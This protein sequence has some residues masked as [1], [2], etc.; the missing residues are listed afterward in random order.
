VAVEQRRGEILPSNVD[1]IASPE[2][3]AK[4]RPGVLVPLLVI[5]VAMLV[6]AAIVLGLTSTRP[7][8]QVAASRTPAPTSAPIRATA[9]SVGAP[10]AQ[11][12]RKP[13]PVAVPMPAVN[14][15]SCDAL[16]STIV[17]MHVHLAIFFDGEE[18]LVPFGVGIGEPW[19]VSASA[20]GPFVEDGSCFYWIHTH[21]E[22]G[23]VHIESPIRRTFTLGDFF[24][25]WE[26][27]LSANQVGPAQGSVI[28]YV[29][30]DRAQINPADIQLSQHTQ[31]QLDVGSDVQPYF[32]EFP[33]GD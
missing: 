8:P 17:H 33:R 2:T 27:P 3:V 21:T 15:I 13:A 18:Q 5:A 28:V 11:G 26:Q 7:T 4:R 16:E 19:Q 14:G 9:T 6:G 23:V 30:G 1:T 32:F 10:Q 22:D 12:Q 25:I 29:N 31:I 24:A 20:A